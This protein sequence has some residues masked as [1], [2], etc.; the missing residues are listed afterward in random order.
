[1]QT[2]N[3]LRPALA[4]LTDRELEVFL[5]MGKGL[6]PFGIANNLKISAKTVSNH[7][8]NM[9]KKMG[10]KSLYELLHYAVKNNYS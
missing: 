10:F 2:L 5:L 8:V 6:D 1:M 4:L 9:M 7:R 3:F